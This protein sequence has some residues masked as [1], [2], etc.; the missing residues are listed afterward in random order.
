MLRPDRRGAAGRTRVAKQNRRLRE[1]SAHRASQSTR[2]S[3]DSI[4]VFCPD[5]RGVAK[6]WSTCAGR[7]V[8]R[9]KI[10]TCV[11]AQDRPARSDRR[12]RVG[13]R[14]GHAIE[15]IDRA[16]ELG[17]PGRATVG[18]SQDRASKSHR[19]ARV[20]VGE[21]N[22]KERIVRAAG[23]GGPGLTAVSGPQDRAIRS[24]RGARVGVSEGISTACLAGR[25][26]NTTSWAL[27]PIRPRSS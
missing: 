18:G 27:P 4:H 19:R 12:A 20:G 6:S 16:A 25:T 15:G 2:F 3:D 11:G 26:T 9:T 7:L 24:Y 8:R 5:C 22:D 23:L 17:D 13:V 10:S 1:E 14:E 21:C